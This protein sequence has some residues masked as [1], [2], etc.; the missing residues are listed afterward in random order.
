MGGFRVT[1]GV[2]V[3]SEVR[4]HSAFPRAGCEG[5][6]PPIFS[7]FSYFVLLILTTLMMDLC[8]YLT[9]VF[10]RISL[11]T[12]DVEHLFMSLF[13]IVHLLW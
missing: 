6:S 9:V 12:R 4:H 10:T 11:K 3:T 1:W 7:G 8:W 2:L 5:S 13:I